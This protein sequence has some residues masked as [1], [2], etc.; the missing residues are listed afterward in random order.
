MLMMDTI[1]VFLI[2]GLAACYGGYTVYKTLTGKSG[3]CGCA[4]DGCNTSTLMDS[5]PSQS[6]CGGK[7]NV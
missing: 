7:K 5:V 2:V 1:A 3:G 6:E 4:C